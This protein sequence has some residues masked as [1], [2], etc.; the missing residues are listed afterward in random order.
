MANDVSETVTLG[1]ERGDLVSVT[2]PLSQSTLSYFDAVGR[3][4]RSVDPMGRATT[5]EYNA[6]NLVTKITDALGGQT[7]FTYDGN[8]NLLTLTDARSKTTTWTY[9]AM[10]RVE[11]RTDPLA[12]D[13]AFT[14]NENGT[15]ETWTDRK[16]QVTSY[17]YDSRDRLTFVGFG[18]TGN[19]PSYA[20]TITTTYDAGDRATETID[21][22]AGT[23]ERTYDLLDR[24]TEEQTSE[25]T[26]TYTYDDADR[27]ATMQVAGQATVSY[28]YDNADRLTGIAQGSA[29]V[30]I[31]YDTADRRTSLTLPNGIVVEY[32]YDAASQL[33]GLTYKLSGTPIGSL[34]YAYDASGQRTELGGTWA[35]SNLPQ[36]LNAATYDDANQITAFGGTAFTYDTNGNL[37]SDGTKTYTWN[38]RNELTGIS[39][40]VSASFA[41]DG[42]GRRRSKTVSGTTTQFLYDRLN[43]VQELAS[44][45]PT[46]NLL[47]GLGIDE[48]FTRTDAAGARNF[49]TDALGSSVALADGSGTVQT[50]YAYEPF[51]ETTKSGAAATSSLGF[52]G[53]E[54]DGTGLY[55]YR[56]RFFEPRTQRFIAEDPLGLLVSANPYAYVNNAPVDWVDPFGLDQKPRPPGV[57][58]IKLPPGKQGQP[59]DWRPKPGPDGRFT[60]K[61][62]ID[63]PTGGQPHATWDGDD[64]WWRYH[65]GKGEPTEHYFPDGT[66]APS[67][68][69]KY[70]PPPQPKPKPTPPPPPVPWWR[71]LLPSRPSLPL[72]TINLCW[73]M[74]SLCLPS[75]PGRA[76]CDTD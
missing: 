1:Y 12:R 18:T 63:S 37:A 51:G 69:P 65:P 53:R 66:R 60:P 31:G 74:P 25:G 15:I 54:E 64:G 14:Y 46:A 71:P 11:T 76:K 7:T 55:H 48:F 21:S 10:D 9:D 72:P 5:Y 19:P 61:Y 67:R 33:T 58:P 2:N 52:T 3:L 23:I 20:S 32:G 29:S 49:L 59:N 70:G 56:M 36:A 22:V 27:R 42:F 34:T 38:A 6:V 41:Y 40:G 39:G 62:P 47:T 8:G 28:T 73:M 75:D 35:R 44:G 68:H 30:G 4:L 13:E 45:T 43:P 17:T 50:E 24:L 26:V 16:G 57:P